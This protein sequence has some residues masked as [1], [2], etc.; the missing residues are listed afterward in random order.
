MGKI[1]TILIFVLISILTWAQ[2]YKEKDKQLHFLAGMIV[3]GVTYEATKNT[4][5]TLLCTIGTT[6]IVGVLK[7]LYDM[8][9]IGNRF[10]LIDLG[11]TIVGGLFSYALAEYLGV[12]GGVIGLVGLTGVYFRY[13]L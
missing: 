4:V 2:S 6:I 5:Y 13:N 1:V 11:Y 7:E 8:K 12:N 9:Q 10:D 3:A